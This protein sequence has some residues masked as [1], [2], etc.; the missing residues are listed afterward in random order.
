MMNSDKNQDELPIMC[1]KCNIVFMSD[2]DYIQHYNDKHKS[3]K[4]V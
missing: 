1:S 3:E 4:A 2:S